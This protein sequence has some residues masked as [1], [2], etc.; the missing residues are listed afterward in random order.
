MGYRAPL[1]IS[2]SRKTSPLFPDFHDFRLELALKTH[3]VIGPRPSGSR[4]RPQPPCAFPNTPTQQS[5]HV[6][7]NTVTMTEGNPVLELDP[8]YDHYDFPTTSPNKQ[9]GHPGHTTPEQ[10]A[11][12]YQLRMKLEA[13]GYT[14]RLDTLTLVRTQR[15]NKL[16]YSRANAK[17]SY[18]FCEPEN[19]TWPFLRRCTLLQRLYALHTNFLIGSLNVRP[20]A[21]GKTSITSSAP[22]TTRRSHRSSN[23]TRNITTRRIKYEFSRSIVEYNH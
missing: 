2:D 10:D 3:F 20:G 15:L 6:L 17:L 8:K 9:S 14:D 1:P 21:K 19:S 11:Q 18:G 22:S 23:I 7:L 13:A 5:H 4:L 16:F 12:V